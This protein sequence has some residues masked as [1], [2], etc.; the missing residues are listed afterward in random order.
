MMYFFFTE[1]PFK[2][3]VYAGLSEVTQWCHLEEPWAATK[4][5]EGANWES[6]E[7]V[8]KICQFDTK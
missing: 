5:V 6:L 2:E 7:G 8:T 3:T 4:R 1:N